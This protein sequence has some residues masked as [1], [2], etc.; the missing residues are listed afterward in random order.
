M[1]RELSTHFSR[2]GSELPPSFCGFEDALWAQAVVEAVR[3]SSRDRRWVK[4]NKLQEEGV[5][6]EKKPEE[7]QQ[8]FF[9]QRHRI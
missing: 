3:A 7:Q 4:V 2:D 6:E 8:F 5:E 1:F 9:S